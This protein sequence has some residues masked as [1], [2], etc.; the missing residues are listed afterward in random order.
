[1]VTNITDIFERKQ[2]EK[3]KMHDCPTLILRKAGESADMK[4][5]AVN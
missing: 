4:R 2:L 3:E 1:M 5:I